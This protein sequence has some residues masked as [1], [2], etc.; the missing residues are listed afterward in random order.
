MC[1]QN[2]HHSILNTAF[3]LKESEEKKCNEMQ[4]YFR[5]IIHIHV[6]MKQ[7]QWLHWQSTGTIGHYAHLLTDVQILVLAADFFPKD[8]NISMAETLAQTIGNVLHN[9]GTNVVVL[10]PDSISKVN[11]DSKVWIFSRG[12]TYLPKACTY[13]YI[14]IQRIRYTMAFD[15]TELFII[16]SWKPDRIL[17]N[18][19]Y[20][21]NK[22]SIP[23]ILETNLCCHMGISLHKMRSQNGQSTELGALWLNCP[24]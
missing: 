6:I 3:E 7:F 18:L 2:F 9:E 21:N 23:T 20:Y 17:N 24:V 11:K 4:L 12:Y 5:V 13:T 15:I 1:S 16:L 14:Y 8:C 10:I 22:V 19:V